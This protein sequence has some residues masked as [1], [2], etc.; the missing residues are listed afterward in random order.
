VNRSDLATPRSKVEGLGS[1]KAGT[2]HF[3]HQ[4]VTAVAL[5]P[6]AIWF[7]I[8]VVTHVG[9]SQSDVAAFFAAPV[10]AVLMFLFLG[11]ALYHMSL[12]L[13]II[14]ED[15][16]HQRG[17]KALLLILNTFFALSVGLAAG[18]ALLK[19]ALSGS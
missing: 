9:A 14:I 17:M 18:L 10:N 13:Q 11:C 5:A 15:Y 1:A 16:I 4:R 8:S 2:S 19:L 7:V 3:W 12:G 6:L